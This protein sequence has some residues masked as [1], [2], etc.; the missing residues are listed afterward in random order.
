MNPF[1]HQLST[2]PSLIQKVKKDEI[3]VA[4][5]LPDSIDGILCFSHKACMQTLYTSKHRV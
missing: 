2:L 4:I 3:G 5:E 1:F